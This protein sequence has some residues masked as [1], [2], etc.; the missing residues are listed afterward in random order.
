[1]ALDK[2]VEFFLVHVTSFNFNSMSI[3]LA[4]EAQIASLITKE[5]KILTNYS[6]FSDVFSEEKALVLPKIT[7]L[8]QY[9]IKLQESQQ[10]SY[11]LIYSLGPIELETFKTYIEI[12]LANGFIWLSKLPASALIFFVRKLNSSFYFC[13]NYQGLNNLTIKNRYPLPLINKSLD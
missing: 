12:K 2:N 5:V 7:N 6:N 3:Y 1:M 4:K 13:V 9:T 8:N 10:P 11:R